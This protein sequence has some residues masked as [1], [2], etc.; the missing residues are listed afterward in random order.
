LNREV[1]T[2]ARCCVVG[3][4]GPC[5]KRNRVIARAAASPHRGLP[6]HREGGQ[7]TTHFPRVCPSPASAF[8]CVVS[9]LVQ[10]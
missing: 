10:A 6:R 3:S 1:L 4:D 8:E 2:H 5:C 9:G 7:H